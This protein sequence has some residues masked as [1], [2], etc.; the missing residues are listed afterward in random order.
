[1]LFWHMH[2]QWLSQVFIPDSLFLMAEDDGVGRKEGKHSLIFTYQTEL[3]QSIAREI[4][5]Q[6]AN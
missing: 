5:F 4:T 2:H 1:M 6:T 3:V